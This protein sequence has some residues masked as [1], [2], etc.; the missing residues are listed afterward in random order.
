MVLF[1]IGVFFVQNVYGQES[2]SDSLYH[3]KITVH[4]DQFE[5]SLENF[6]F[7]VSIFE[8]DDLKKNV[9]LD[10][11][12]IY[13]TDSYYNELYF[14]IEKWDPEKG[15]LIAWVNVN[16][17]ENNNSFLIHYGGSFAKSSEFD[18]NTWNENY[19]LVL[20]LNENFDDSSCN[21]YDGKNF[22]T[23]QI[24][25]QIARGAEFNGNSSLINFGD[26]DE[27]DDLAE[28]TISAWVRNHSLDSDVSIV[29]KWGNLGNSF[30][31]W[32]DDKDSSDK[33]S[34]AYSFLVY[35]YGTKPS[36]HISKRIT[37]PLDSAK[38]DQWQYVVS[39]FTQNNMTRGDLELW[40]DGNQEIN[41]HTSPKTVKNIFPTETEVVIG[42]TQNDDYERF[43]GGILDEVRISKVKFDENWIQAEYLNQKEPATF[44]S[45]GPT[46]EHSPPCPFGTK[47][48][49][50]SCDLDLA[51]FII[52]AAII[53]ATATILSAFIRKSHST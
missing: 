6:P 5:G 40:I 43:Y 46:I 48:V 31:F 21:K 32:I 33:E 49:D 45:L 4:P 22:D 51:V 52:I 11:K 2:D 17:T 47:L 1:F 35:E 7:L 38:L 13:F 34:N 41:G 25:A 8:D 53:T 24:D 29:S 44:Y 36:P 26:I 27:F 15:T 28:L 16:L 23:F 3:K 30:L 10:S 18:C 9:R 14:E 39:S 20:H 19:I 37:G 42:S 50:G 12:N